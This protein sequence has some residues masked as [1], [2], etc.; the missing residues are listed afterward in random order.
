MIDRTA[1][2]H[3]DRREVEQTADVIVTPARHIRHWIMAYKLE[4]CRGCNGFRI[5]ELGLAHLISSPDSDWSHQGSTDGSGPSFA[6][7]ET[8][9]RLTC[10]SRS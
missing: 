9:R 8:S 7:A 5:E 2:P 6:S 1:L 4:G 3:G 10:R